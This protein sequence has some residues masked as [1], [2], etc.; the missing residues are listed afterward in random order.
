MDAHLTESEIRGYTGHTLTPEQILRVHDHLEHCTACAASLR[1]DAS[2]EALPLLFR[3]AANTGCDVTEDEL[4]QLVA[5]TLSRAREG[6]VTQHL[7]HCTVCSSAVEDLRRFRNETGRRR[8]RWPVWGLAAAAGIAGIVL[9]LPRHNVEHAPV[10]VASLRDG[11]GIIGLTADGRLD[12]L[13]APPA[14]QALV[15]QAL[16]SGAIT[17]PGSETAATVLR[18]EA[19]VEAQFRPLYPMGRVLSDRPEFRWSELAGANAYEVRVFDERFEER[20][21]SGKLTSNT[22]VPDKPLGRGT[23]LAW[24]V[25]AYRGRKRITEPGPS[26]PEAR[27]EIAGDAVARRI[28]Q[29]GPSHLL[30]AILCAQERMP[31][32]ARA[33]L[34]LLAQ[35]NPGSQ[36]ADSLKRS[37]QAAPR[38]PFTRLE[39][40]TRDPVLG[41]RGDGWE[42]AGVFNPAVVHHGRKFVMLYRAQDKAGVSRIGYATSKDGRSFARRA[43]PVLSP[44]AEYEANGGVEDPRLVKIGSLYYLTYT[45]YNKKD[46][47]L[48][49]AKSADLV[50]WTRM[51]VIMPAYKGKWNTGW[52]KSGAILDTKINGRYW[53]YFMADAK[54][55]PGQMGVAWSTDLQHWTEALDQPVVATRPGKVDSKVAEPGPAPVLTDAGIFLIYNGADDQLIY[56]TGW[57]IFD[58]NDPVKVIARSDD[59]IFAPELEWEKK[60]QVPNVVFVEGMVRSGSRWLFWYGGAD[61]FVGFAQGRAD[62]LR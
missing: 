12:G 7:Q 14:D 2:V 33:E 53:M 38:L 4:V 59:P 26:Q 55:R 60:G 54:D 52:T 24:Q 3:E 1:P 28:E 27:F 50:H 62:L 37:A 11:S 35:A 42:S 15:R 16:Q 56:R 49:I 40:V 48:C 47:Q 5:G 39:R 17:L 32:E 58:P 51:G 6:I 61:Q 21:R 34:D 18:G 19:P 9:A 45:G 23:Q 41:P 22:W 8:Y 43:D 20:A 44:E 13:N 25:T 46:A 31:R 29:A 30:R 36:T 57:V 10:Y